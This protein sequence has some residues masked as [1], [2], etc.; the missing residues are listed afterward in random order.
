MLENAFDKL[1]PIDDFIHKKL[2]SLF[3]LYL[4]V[5]GM[6]AAVSSFISTKNLKLVLDTQNM[7]IE[8]YK[9][10]I[11]KYDKENKLYLKIFQGN[12]F[13]GSQCERGGAYSQGLKRKR[14]ESI[15]SEFIVVA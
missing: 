6:P 3:E 14:Q 9:R 15:H 2:L 8:L 1:T 12:R 11:S 7:I 10:D 13:L 4:I 5:G